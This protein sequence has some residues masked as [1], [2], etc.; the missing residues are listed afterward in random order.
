MNASHIHYMRRAIYLDK[1]GK[2]NDRG[3]F[4]AIIVK[5]GEII[6]EGFNKVKNPI[7]L[8]TAR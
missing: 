8:Y 4:G 5:D 6:A 3:V 1:L 2:E 7:R